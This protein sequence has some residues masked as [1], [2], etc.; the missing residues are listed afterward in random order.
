[1]PR[2]RSAVSILSDSSEM[3]IDGIAEAELAKLQRQFRI[4][5]GDRQAYSIETQNL[6]RRQ[7]QEI[8]KL[9]KEHEELQ[10]S[11]R[12]SESHARRLRDTEATQT[13]RSTL[14]RRDEVE[15]Q[16]EREK[17]AIA[18]LDQE[19][20]S[21]ER[22][23]ADR[24]RGGSAVNL[25]RKA[26]A[27]QT[28]QASHTLENKLH[29]ALTSFNKQL[30]KIGSLREELETLHVER[31]RFQHLYRRLIKELQELRKDI[32]DVVDQSTSAYDA[33]VEA[34]CKTV[35]LN[36]KAVKDLAQYNVEMQE[37]ERIIA[38]E[39]RLKT[40]MNVKNQERADEDAQDLSRK[41]ATEEREKRKTE[42]GEESIAS[43]EEAFIRIQRITGEEDLDLLV[44]KFIEVE[45]RNF[46]LFNYVNEQNNEAETLRDQ[47]SQIQQEMAQFRQEGQRQERERGALL[48]EIGEQ[49]EETEKQTQAYEQRA[50]VLAKILDQLKTGVS[51]VF[52]KIGCDRSV[53][54]D[55][56]G[57]SSGIRDSDLITYLSLVE[58]KTNELLTIQSYLMSKD[59]EKD[60]D[61]EDV[62]RVLLGQSPQLTRQNLSIL[63]PS[64]GDTI[65]PE[66]SSLTDEERP[67]TRNELQER[68]L[69]GIASTRIIVST[70]CTNSCQSKLTILPGKWGGA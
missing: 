55:M 28:H 53:I 4:M 40:F 69:K 17:Q 20:F 33:R 51:D 14:E 43:L 59:L 18:Q 19:I 9:Q 10:C 30:A 46:A 63:P 35:T 32:G 29:R 8:Q 25:N 31:D 24:R 44:M 62:A 66:E 56:L 36:E 2:G 48:R 54:E 22:K 6:I 64:I 15:E 61:P 27:S 23:L 41:Q 49:Q 68:V 21:L 57:S 38:H 26:Q 11:L 1:M 42:S 3:D 37:L 52:Q 5:E 16:L 50:T 12:V 39:H 13:L 7:L 58:Q 65:D 45:D 47:I 34:Q 60:Y 70:L 67:L